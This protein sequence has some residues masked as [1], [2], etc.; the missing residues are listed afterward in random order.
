MID[1]VLSIEDF[2]HNMGMED[3]LKDEKTKSA[4]VRQFEI[5]G[6]ASKALPEDVQSMEPDVPWNKI[7]GMR[8][9][10]IHAYFAVDHK[11]V[12]DTIEHELPALKAGLDRLYNDLT[13]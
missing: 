4:V 9:R 11:L 3:F 13:K 10:L 2:T 6:E 1:A 7:A 8:D 5:L 12:W